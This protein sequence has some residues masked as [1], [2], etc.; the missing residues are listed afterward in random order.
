MDGLCIYFYLDL[1]RSQ[2]NL[3]KH[4]SEIMKAIKSKL[5]EG[6]NS[7]GIVVF[8]NE[9]HFFSFVASTKNFFV[10]AMESSSK[11]YSHLI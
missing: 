11:F 6:N 9:N 1:L 2:Q 7:L 3:G 8:I 10:S 5:F 4:M